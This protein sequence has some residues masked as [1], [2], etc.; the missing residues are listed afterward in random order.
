MKNIAAVIILYH[1]KILEVEKNISLLASQVSHCFIVDNSVPKTEQLMLPDNATLISLGENV[2]IAK[3][4]NIGLKKAQEQNA[5]FTV[6]FDQDSQVT[7]SIVID[8]HKS[9]YLEAAKTHKVIAVGPRPFDI[10]TQKIMIPSVQKEHASLSELT[11]C[12]QII[13]SG[14]MIKMEYLDEVGLFLEE[15]FIDGVDHEWCWRAKVKGFS[16][17]INESVIMNHQ[18]GDARGRFLGI[19][20]KIGSPIRLFYQFRNILI[21]SRRD[22]V[23]TYWKLRNLISIPVR[24]VIFSIR[25]PNRSKRIRFMLRGIFKGILYNSKTINN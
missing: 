14:K 13:A 25:G 5:D 2:G 7:K 6:L 20:Y 1:P 18:L 8:L 10:F 12:S 22:Y 9:Y 4:Q 16:V 15:L 21:L 19:T 11:I 23:P 3:A 24:F 17:A